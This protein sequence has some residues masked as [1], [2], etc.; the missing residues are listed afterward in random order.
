MGTK[1]ILRCNPFFPGGFDPVPGVPLNLD[2]DLDAVEHVHGGLKHGSHAAT[3][4]SHNT[5]EGRADGTDAL[6]KGRGE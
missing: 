4:H 2:I 6:I 3:S 5:F 1:R